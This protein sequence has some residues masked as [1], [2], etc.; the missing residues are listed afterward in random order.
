[1]DLAWLSPTHTGGRT[2]NVATRRVLGVGCKGT[3]PAVVQ[4]APVGQRHEV[5]RADAEHGL[6]AA[7]VH[8]RLQ[9]RNRFQT[10]HIATEKSTARQE[11][12]E[13]GRS[14]INLLR[15]V[16]GSPWKV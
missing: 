3:D 11:T 14:V 1:M 6:R 16:V 2:F 8:R 13:V 5:A 9:Q 12:C 4:H 10:V 15:H 7:V